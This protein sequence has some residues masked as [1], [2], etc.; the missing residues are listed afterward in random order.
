MRKHF[1]MGTKL[2]DLVVRYLGRQR[3]NIRIYCQGFV[4]C[5]VDINLEKKKMYF[6]NRILTSQTF[7]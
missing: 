2:C 6:Q 3:K 5:C 4:K 7:L 1:S